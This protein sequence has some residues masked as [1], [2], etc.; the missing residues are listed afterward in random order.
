MIAYPSGKVASHWFATSERAKTPEDGHDRVMGADLSAE[1]GES[2]MAERCVW[3]EDDAMSSTRVD[4]PLYS[5]PLPGA[6]DN[7]DFAETEM[8]A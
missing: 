7:V 3:R 5:P 1:W 4:P 8:G 2:L 6:E